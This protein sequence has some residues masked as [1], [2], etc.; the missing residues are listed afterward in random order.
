MNTL[1]CLRGDTADS[2][3]SNNLVD[4][5]KVRGVQ[6]SPLLTQRMRSFCLG[7]CLRSL[8]FIPLIVHCPCNQ[9]RWVFHGDFETVRTKAIRTKIEYV[10][11]T[12]PRLSKESSPAAAATPSQSSQD[13]EKCKAIRKHGNPCL[14]T[15]YYETL[16]SP[17]LL[18]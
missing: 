17:T 9:T 16:E 13:E 10:I 12:H 6:S 7:L 11:H 2:V 5:G 15:F 3:F 1:S 18:R 8:W 14:R 4:V